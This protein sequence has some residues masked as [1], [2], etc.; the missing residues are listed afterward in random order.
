MMAKNT[1]WRLLRRNISAGQIAGYALASFVGLTIVL[2]ALQFYRDVTSVWDADD[3]FI[4]NDFIVIS[5][6]VPGGGALFGSA[7]EATRFSRGEIE[8]LAGQPWVKNVGEF[9]AADFNVY[10]KVEMG[11]ASMGTA[12][13]LEAIPDEFFDIRPQ[14]WD[15]EPGRSPYVPIVLS[16]EYLSLYN[17]GFAT[18]RGMPQLS[19]E[20]IG[21]VP[22]KLSLSGNGSQE[23]VDARIVGFSSRLNT[24][25]VP[26]QF[27]E[28]ANAKFSENP[29]Q[30]PS[31]LIVRLERP[32][33][34]EAENYLSA[35]GYETATDRSA[36]GKTAYFLSIVT[37]IVVAVGLIISLLAFFIL[38]LSIYLLLQKNREKTRTL[39]LLGY[40]PRQVATVYHYIVL[41]V[42]ALVLI[43]AIVVV[44]VGSNFWRG[45]LAALGVEPTSIWPVAG[46]GLVLM[47]L[48]TVANLLAINRRIRAEF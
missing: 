34:P 36:N 47:L 40:S 16:K 29:S 41:S 30:E 21:M 22:L 15:Y 17:F 8:E 37:S 23:W 39:L 13:F 11:G 5:K 7:G 2:T 14:G 4:T 44:A 46:V 27:M 25:A 1:L 20:L 6:R 3:S 24:I 42:N 43:G 19:E 9:E 26:R 33:D 18:S 28:A 32:G 10:A 45:P 48:I 38:L 12:L 35:H 31:R